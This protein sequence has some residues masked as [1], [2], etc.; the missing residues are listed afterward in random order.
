MS[1]I[2]HITFHLNASAEYTVYP[3]GGGVCD[4]GAWYAG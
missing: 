4:V 2:C 1:G 3:D